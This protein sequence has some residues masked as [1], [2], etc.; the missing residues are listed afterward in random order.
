MEAIACDSLCYTFV[1][2]AHD[3]PV[4]SLCRQLKKNARYNISGGEVETT[5][6]SWDLQTVLQLAISKIKNL[7]NHK[8]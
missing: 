8:A 2:L 7:T 6:F 3:I 4:L 5:N 1:F